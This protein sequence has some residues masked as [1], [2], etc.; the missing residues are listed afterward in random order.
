MPPRAVIV[1]THFVGVSE[2]SRD[3][4]LLVRV[5]GVVV[6]C[7]LS[8]TL[9]GCQVRRVC[10]ELCR[11]LPQLEIN[12]SVAGQLRDRTRMCVV[13]SSRVGMMRLACCPTSGASCAAC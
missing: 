2:A 8:L 5:H 1:L 11:A 7:A 4:R 3:V 12:G 10:V 13:S 6:L 9:V